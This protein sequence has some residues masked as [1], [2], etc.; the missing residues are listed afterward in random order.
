[1]SRFANT[2]VLTLA[3]AAFNRMMPNVRVRWSSAFVGGLA[4]AL[5]IAINHRIAAL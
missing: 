2:F 4:I 3:F 5:L 1:M